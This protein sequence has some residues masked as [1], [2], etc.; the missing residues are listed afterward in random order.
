MRAIII[1][2]I[3]KIVMARNAFVT[4]VVKKILA[5]TNAPVTSVVLSVLPVLPVHKDRL[6]QEVYPEYR[7]LSV[8][9]VLRVKPVPLV[10]RV[11][12]V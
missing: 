10:R 2:A 11:L 8:R 7:V 3:R 9:K 4:V 1:I 5:R 6:G 12:P